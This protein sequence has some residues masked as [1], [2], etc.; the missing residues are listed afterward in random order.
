MPQSADGLANDPVPRAL[1]VGPRLS[2]TAD[3][4]HHECGI[5]A[6]EV[7]IAEPPFLETAGS[8]VLHHHVALLDEA[9]HD[10]L[11]FGRA[12]IDGYQGLVSEYA[13]SVERLAFRLAPDRA[14]V[15]ADEGLDFDHFRAEVRE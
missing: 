5:D 10:V 13:C 3:S 1:A 4:N 15:I 6:G 7:R 9:L 14:Y 12:Q 11:A 2:V 8:E